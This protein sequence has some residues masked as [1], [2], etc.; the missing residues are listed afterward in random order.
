MRS[1]GVLLALGALALGIYFFMHTDSNAC[2]ARITAF[3]DSLVTGYG[4]PEGEDAFSVLSRDLNVSITNEGV[5]GDTSGRAL[6]RI[7]TIV[8]AKPDIVIVLV[9]GNDA[10]HRLPVSETEKNIGKILERL[11]NTGIHPILVGVLG[12]FPTDPYAPMFERLATTYE[13]PLVPNIL[14]GLI[15]R[16]E[17][18]SDAIHPNSAGYARIA[19]RLLPAVTSVCTS[20]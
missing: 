15:G 17:F 2:T 16:E 18:M 1:I 4:A 12:G 13:V 20:S 19:E 5:S 6:A 8:A 9:G 7:D 10:L 14:R 11:T 3:G